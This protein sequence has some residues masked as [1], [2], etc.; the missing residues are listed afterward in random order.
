MSNA[1][2][3]INKVDFMLSTPTNDQFNS[4]SSDLML[5]SVSLEEIEHAYL[6]DA[7]V[8]PESAMLEAVSTTRMRLSRTMQAFVKKLNQGLSGTGIV[9]GDSGS[10]DNPNSRVIAG[11]DIGRV[12][13]VGNIPIIP[14]RIPL[15]DGQSV[16]LIFHCPTSTGSSIKNDDVLTAFRFLLNKRDVSHVV[17]PISGRD[18]SLP[19]VCQSLSNLIERNSSKFKRQQANAIKIK[20]DIEDELNNNDSLENQKVSLIETG[21]QLQST[22]DNDK[23]EL[24]K[25]QLK[26]KKQ[27]KINDELRLNLENMKA[28]KNEEGASGTPPANDDNPKP[29]NIEK[30]DPDSADAIAS[31]AISFL[32]SVLSMSDKTTHELTKIR[33]NV[34]EAIAALNSA[35]IYEENADL[36][37]RAVNHLSAML[38]TIARNANAGEQ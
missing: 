13:R 26:L 17:A 11:A 7:C 18:I 16:S 38:A 32:N 28:K 20:T 31:A 34:R 19:Q 24:E 12:R 23:I 21:D 30:N 14:A 33:G 22:I 9:A 1:V 5:E 36:V 15:T 4:L 10:D 35:A 29:D 6:G 3:V 8:S 37:S 27:S 2:R 25:I